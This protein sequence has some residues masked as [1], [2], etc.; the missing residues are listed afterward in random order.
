MNHGLRGFQPQPPF[1]FA[2]F[3]F[4][5]GS[6][7]SQTIA[8]QPHCPSFFVKK[9]FSIEADFTVFP[10][11]L[12][13]ALQSATKGDFKIPCSTKARSLALFLNSQRPNPVGGGCF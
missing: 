11:L 9:S 5:G 13:A 4:G 10:Y 6:I 3:P 7:V 8:S 12:N 1:H 2:A